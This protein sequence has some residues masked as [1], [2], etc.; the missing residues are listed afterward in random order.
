MAKDQADDDFGEIADRVN[1][2][3]FKRL[4]Q[5]TLVQYSAPPSKA[6]LPNAEPFIGSSVL[7]QPSYLVNPD[8]NR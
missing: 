8:F 5:A 6:L 1:I 4:A 3:K 2:V 7:R